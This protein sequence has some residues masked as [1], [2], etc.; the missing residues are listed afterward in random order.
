MVSFL[1]DVFVQGRRAAGA[2]RIDP[3]PPKVN[4]HP[5]QKIVLFVRFSISPRQHAPAEGTQKV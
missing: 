3:F 4:A 2:R 1:V 5:L